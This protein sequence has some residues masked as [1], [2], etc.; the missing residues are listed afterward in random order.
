MAG[1]GEACSYVAAVLFAAE[2]N[3]ITKRQF[4]SKSL[5]CSR[6]PPTFCAVKF[7]ELSTI[8]FLTP[9]HKRKVPS[10]DSGQS[11]KTKLE[12]PPPTAV[13]EHY[14]RLTKTKGKPA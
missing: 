5:P 6:L 10:T 12:I 4:S 3:S 11:K 2:A 14:S 13:E 9:K 7:A 8:D 1:L